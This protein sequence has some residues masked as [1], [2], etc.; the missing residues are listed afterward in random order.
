MYSDGGGRERCV[1]VWRRGGGGGGG[2]QEPIVVL[3]L[4]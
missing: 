1:C 4:H 2:G 3:F